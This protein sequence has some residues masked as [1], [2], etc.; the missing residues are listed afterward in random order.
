VVDGGEPGVELEGIRWNAYC[1]LAK[2][3][4]AYVF[5]AMTCSIESYKTSNLRAFLSALCIQFS[6]RR[7]KLKELFI[8]WSAHGHHLANA[9][10]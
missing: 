8:R 1:R 4:P 9:S 7:L 5:A 2:F 10:E 3:K 6:W